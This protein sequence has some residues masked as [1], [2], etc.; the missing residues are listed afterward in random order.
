MKSMSK[1]VA[2]GRVDAGK[3]CLLRDNQ[4][5]VHQRMQWGDSKDEGRVV[6]RRKK[7]KLSSTKF[8]QP[9]ILSTDE[10]RLL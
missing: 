10:I 1:G 9:L 6:A 7:G 3:G 8:V 2:N 5:A 4:S